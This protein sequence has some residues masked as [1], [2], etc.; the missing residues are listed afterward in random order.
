MK[1]KWEDYPRDPGK[2]RFNTIYDRY[3]NTKEFNYDDWHDFSKWYG[4]KKE[5]LEKEI[6]YIEYNHTD[7]N[8]ISTPTWMS[9][10]ELMRR[11]EVTRRLNLLKLE[12]Y[13]HI[14]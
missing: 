4:R 11:K 3:K 9:K 12:L 10:D 7:M 8:Y 1:W 6:K 5:R 2:S 14:N 13:D